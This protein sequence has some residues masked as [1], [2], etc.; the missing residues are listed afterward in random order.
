[1]KDWS[2][3]VV[4]DRKS[5]PNYALK[6]GRY[7]SWDEQRK[8][9]PDLCDLIGP[10]SVARGRMIAFIWAYQLG[11]DVVAS[12]DDDNSPYED[13]GNDVRVGKPTR[14]MHYQTNS[15]AFDP[16]SIHQH[17]LNVHCW[18]RGFP[19][20]LRGP[21]TMVRSE[22]MIVP[23]VQANLWDGDLDVDATVRIA[24]RPNLVLPRANFYSTNTFSPVNTQNTFIARKALKHYPANIPFIGR[25]D[26]IWASYLFEARHPGRVVY[27]KPTVI[28]A[29][30]RSV[31]S[32]L[33]DLE[34]EM[35]LYRNN[36]AFLGTLA[37]DGAEAAIE[38][39]PVKAREAI[40]MYESY[41]HN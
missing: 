15:L 32:M 28:A 6:R 2:L 10:G 36:M 30:N 22:K 23:L 38:L 14:V 41:F 8:R 37:K 35:F 12:I 5:P 31:K 1:M 24:T 11:A 9:Y 19:L 7:M 25:A 17:E 3:L 20:E 26:D 27:G 34:S 33:N 13:W 18:H 21:Q 29:Q 40:K 4:G 39:L 16:L